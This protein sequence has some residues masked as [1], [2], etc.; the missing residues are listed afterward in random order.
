[1][2]INIRIQ[3]YPGDEYHSKDY[4]RLYEREKEERERLQR[5][6]DRCNRQINQLR[7]EQQLKISNDHSYSN[8][9]DTMNIHN[10]T[11]SNNC[12]NS[13]IP[14]TEI[15]RLREEISKMKEENGALIRVISKLSKP[16]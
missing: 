16:I 1:M 7:Q 10:Y 15:V 8:T 6:L 2:Y 13:Q 11:S 3:G 5:E 14:D 12:N 9:S 4:K